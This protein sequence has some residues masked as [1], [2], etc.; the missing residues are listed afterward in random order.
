MN[1]Q[2][3]PW[4]LLE[5]AGNRRN[6]CAFTLV[7]LLVVIAVIAILAA[8]LLPALGKASAKAQQVKCASNLQQVHLGFRMYA[9]DFGGRL[10]LTAHS[11]TET[12]QMW[13]R[14]LRPYVGNSEAI[15]LCPADPLHRERRIFGGTSYILNEFLSVPLEDAFGQLV[16]PLPR[17]DQLRHPAETILLFEVADEYGTSVDIDHTHSRTWLQDGWRGVIA[18]IRPD[19]HRTGAPAEDRTTGRANYL[20]VDGHVEAIAAAEIRQQIEQGINI[21]Q[22]P[23]F[24]PAP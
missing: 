23:E 13:I 18:D 12:N 19:R 4:G 9:D 2:N 21:A 3:C 24:R 7:E 22:P 10:P 11:T 17:L 20:Y 14:K 5:P 8:M 1:C 16:E 6:I 15:R